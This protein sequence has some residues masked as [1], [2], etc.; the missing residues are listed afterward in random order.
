MDLDHKY[1]S[2]VYIRLLMDM[3]QSWGVDPDEMLE[4]TG[5]TRAELADP[6]S[7]LSLEQ[8]ITLYECA[9]RLSP[10]PE[11]ALR[12]GQSTSLS[13]HGVYG[14]AILTSADLAHALQIS[15]RFSK[16]AGIVTGAGAELRE[17]SNGDYEIR[18]IDTVQRPGVHRASIEEFFSAANTTIR[19]LTAGAFK[20]KFL[21]LDY[22]EPQYRSVYD[23]IFACPLQFDSAHNRMVIDQK[24]L[25]MRISTW[26]PLTLQA[27]ERQC[28]QMLEQLTESESFVDEVRKVMLMQPCDR[29]G[30]AFV[31]EKLHMSTRNL[32]RKL[33]ND[34]LSFQKVFDDVRCQLAKN[35][36]SESRLQLE[37]IVP[38]LGFADPSNFRRAFKKWTGLTPTGYRASLRETRAESLA[39]KA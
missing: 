8:E 31:A 1:I 17:H 22:P 14:Y 38:L 13:S 25:Q 24:D 12:V 35:Y 3:L 39:R 19:E 16:L 36:L 11:W 9:H 30:A 10:K 5:I 23:E 7:L 37:D 26:D 6:T 33:E 15:V 28:E 4:G 21:Y 27:C 34:G 18:L 29:R 20:P 32:R 2:P